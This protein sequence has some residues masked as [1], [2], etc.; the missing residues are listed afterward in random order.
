[1]RICVALLLTVL[2][3]GC[4][5]PPSQSQRSSQK[6]SQE[7]E[8]LQTSESKQGTVSQPIIVICNVVNSRDGRCVTPEKDGVINDVIIKSQPRRKP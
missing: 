4:S 5:I 6:S 8:A 7:Q 3:T 2:L 1:M